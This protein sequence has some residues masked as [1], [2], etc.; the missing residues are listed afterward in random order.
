MTESK[1]EIDPQHDEEVRRS[2]AQVADDEINLLE[3]LLVLVKNKRMIL[4]SS[5]VA[6]VL[7]C[8]LSL[9]MPN[10]Y[11]ATARILPPQE[12]TGGL[13]TMLGGASDLAALAGI[14]IDNSSGEL[15]VGMLQSRSIADALIDRFKL[16]EVYD[17]DYRVKT[18]EALSEHATISLGKDDGIISV[19]VEDEEPVRAAAMANAYVEEFKKLNLNLNLSKSGRERLFLENRLEL[20]KV[21]LKNA[22]ERL[23]EF[24]KSNKTIR[25]DDQAT[26]IIEAIAL[27]K[28]EQASKEVELGVLKSSQTE[29]NPQVKALRESIV[30][31]KAQIDKLAKSS[32]SGTIEDIFI[33]TADVPE[34]GIQ[35][36]RLLRDLKIQE[37]L[38]ELLT[39]QYEMAK[40]SEA[41]DT[42]SIQ[43]LDDALVPDKKAKPKRSLIV[44]AITFV[45][46]FFSLLWAFIREYG[47][48]MPEEDRQL[49]TEIKHRARFR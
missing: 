27:L 38:F 36:G 15:Y 28:G 20:V 10:I 7:A 8:I 25:I 14:S 41:K 16:M 24:Q 6:F 32:K 44:L 19:T 18:Y 21:D 17:Q 49:W 9:L 23:T 35:Y 29:Q 47:Q 42:S 2:A 48:R 34:L 46:G 3:Y 33:A 39:K 31:I 13:G 12:K 11:S 26:V 4:T 37:A 45:V 43:V 1:S 40:I 5:A 22:E 30:Q